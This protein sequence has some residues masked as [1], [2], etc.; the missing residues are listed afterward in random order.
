[1][2]THP[3]SNTIVAPIQY[4][5]ATNGSCCSTDHSCNL[6]I[7]ECNGNCSGIYPEFLEDLYRALA[8]LSNFEKCDSS[9]IFCLGH[10][11]GAQICT[12]AAIEQQG[13][14]GIIGI[15]GIYN[16]SKFYVGPKG[17]GWQCSVEKAFGSDG[18]VWCEHGDNACNPRLSEGAYDGPKALFVHSLEDTLTLPQQGQEMSCRLNGVSQAECSCMDDHECVC[19]RAC[20]GNESSIA[21]YTDKVSGTHF[22]V[23]S[24][25][26]L[27]N[28]T[29]DFICPLTVN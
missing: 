17:E 20:R 5:L 7:N 15:E 26:R 25:E 14:S 11:A 18:L 19:L 6:G 28:I 12:Q 21:R 27:A 22:G 1:M 24:Q 2:R 10:S 8:F 4:R 9:K 13:L 29:R 3:P 16:L 23:L